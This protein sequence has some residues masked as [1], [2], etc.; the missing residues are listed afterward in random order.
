MFFRLELGAAVVSIGDGMPMVF[1]H[2]HKHFPKTNVVFMEV[3][4][5]LTS[6]SL[7]SSA[8]RRVCARQLT[9]IIQT[10]QVVRY[11][12]GMKVIEWLSSNS[13]FSP[14]SDGGWSDTGDCFD[15]C[16]RLRVWCASC[17]DFGCSLSECVQALLKDLPTFVEV[18]SD[19]DLRK[20]RVQVEVR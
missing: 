2:A 19:G 15:G 10:K 8:L 16:A 20:F 1:D 9:E 11:A 14:F 4:S 7:V 5:Y 13:S 12:C 18:G 3:R 6:S 17:V